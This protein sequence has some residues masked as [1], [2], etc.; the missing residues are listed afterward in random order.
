VIRKWALT[1]ACL[2]STLGLPAFG[3]AAGHFGLTAGAGLGAAY[4]RVADLELADPVLEDVQARETLSTNLT[5]DNAY[6]HLGVNYRVTAVQLRE[7]PELN[8]IDQGVGIL[9]DADRWLRRMTGTGHLTITGELA[10][11]PSLPPL[12]AGRPSVPNSPETPPPG[13]GTTP[14]PP[15]TPED[16][17]TAGNLVN[18]R[19]D[20]SGYA[21]I[22]GLAYDDEL[23]PFSSYRVGWLVR[24]NR[25]N[26]AVIGDSATLAVNGDYLSRLRVGEAGVGVSHSRYVRGGISDRQ[27][28]DVH[29]SLAQ[30]TY[31]SGWRI[32]PGVSY[33]TDTHVYGASLNLGAYTR[34]RVLSY[35]GYY[36][37]SYDLLD[38][39]G[40]T[41]ART[42][43][44]G[45]T[46]Q[47]TRPTR[48]PRHA[49]ADVVLSSRSRAYNMSAEQSVL[50]TDKVRASIGYER[51]LL[52]WT[53][54]TTDQLHHRH[55][56]TVLLSLNWQFL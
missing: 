20:R 44:V 3:H 54:A 11:N 22:Y 24:D 34:R 14:A 46:V 30:G 49:G 40:V 19:E 37:T 9:L 7:N 56:D 36:R 41:L 10:I 26:S 42:Q 27:T 12:D 4:I 35:Q 18:I 1:A 52:R 45:F 38:V 39:A 47:P 33:R 29:A 6:L 25:Y 8:Y 17:L 13:D 50:V 16:L 43:H 21:L 28:Y 31:R 23:S 51:G 48:Y 32:A 5:F 15:P 55:A 2:L 53:D